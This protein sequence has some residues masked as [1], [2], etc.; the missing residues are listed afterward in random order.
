M[1]AAALSA[2]ALLCHPRRVISRVQ[3]E[4]FKALQQ[5]SID[6]ERFTVFVGAN[7]TGKT[8]VLHGLDTFSRFSARRPIHE[9]LALTSRFSDFMRTLGAEGDVTVSVTGEATAELRV[10]PDSADDPEDFD[11]ELS[12]GGHKVT[13]KDSTVAQ[14]DPIYKALAG[15]GFSD[16]IRL[17]LE[18]VRLGAA[19]YVEDDHPQVGTDG[20]GLAS[21]LAFSHGEQSGA[22]ARIEASLRKVV[23]RTGRIRTYPSDVKRT[24]IQVVTVNRKL[25]EQEIE[26]TYKGQRFEL[27]IDGVGYVPAEMLSEGTLLV[28]GL[29]TVLHTTPGLRLLLLDDIERGLHPNAQRDLVRSLRAVLAE[30]PQLQIV[31]TTHSPYALDSFEPGEVRVMKLDPQGHAVCKALTDHPDWPHWKDL[32]NPGEFW[33]SVGEDWI[34]GE[35]DG[36]A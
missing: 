4:N 9:N 5:V 30:N 12:L 11:F 13:R 3:F 15:S 18:P 31:C 7:A 10:R 14:W 16:S 1:P 34:F 21:V 22:I 29:L 25:I 19:S 24:L 23:P 27:E 17:R 32:M 8:S 28:L 36:A 20:S 26:R 33:S 35:R 2:H 6:L